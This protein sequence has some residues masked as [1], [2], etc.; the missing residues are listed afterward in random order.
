M[1][2]EDIK[3]GPPQGDEE[4]AAD[5]GSAGDDMIDGNLLVFCVRE[6]ITK[7]ASLKQH[8][9]AL[10]EVFSRRI[11]GIEAALTKCQSDIDARQWVNPAL[12]SGGVPSS[13]VR[14]E[15]ARD[16]LERECK[17]SSGAEVYFQVKDGRLICRKRM[18]DERKSL[19]VEPKAA[20]QLLSDASVKGQCTLSSCTEIYLQVKGGVSDGWFLSSS[21]KLS[22]TITL[23]DF[24]Y[25]LTAEVRRFD[26]MEEA[27]RFATG[28]PSFNDGK[29]IPVRYYFG[30][31]GIWR[32]QGR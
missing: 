24:T 2:N 22:G 30:D 28:V 16:D 5:E 11:K 17:L 21:A 14:V 18:D 13:V 8:Q 10:I 3:K 32:Q 7:V 26:S 6:L 27:K 29:L 4:A 15:K 1:P 20:S 25:P 31:D 23:S 9:D 12:V 19:S